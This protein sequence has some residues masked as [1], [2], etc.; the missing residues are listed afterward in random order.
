M[1]DSHD[2]AVAE[3]Q[4]AITS[5]TTLAEKYPQKLE[6][7]QN[8]A[9]VNN[10]LG[11]TLRLS[12]DKPDDAK[13]AY[14]TALTLQQ[15]LHGQSPD[16]ATYQRELARTHYNRGILYGKTAEPG[17][18]AFT[19]A[20]SDFRE[21]MRLLE[22]LVGKSTDLRTSQDLARACN[23]LAALLER[24]DARVPDAR[25]LYER[26]ID[27]IGDLVAKRP[28]NRQYRFELAKF[29]N[30]LSYLLDKSGHP[31]LAEQANRRALA[32]IAELARPAQSLDM[33]RA[34][35]HNLRGHILQALKPREAIAEYRASLNVW[36]ALAQAGGDRQADFHQRF[37]DLLLNLAAFSKGPPRRADAEALTG[38]A[39]VAYIA[40][41]ERA[42]TAGST[43]SARNVVDTLTD[44]MPELSD[45]VRRQM[46]GPLES[47]QKKLK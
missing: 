46:T 40:V 39:V 30:N 22:P 47:L 4:R 27:L 26:A 29:S 41:G 35:T 38:E 10:S 8:L 19:Q 33:E 37:G 17:Q 45:P 18:A 21:A 42:V 44:V 34:D 11:E 20:E 28:D 16:N 36:V 1:L 14:A 3:Y 24:D 15:A 23:N 32:L 9:S 7:R 2:A 5:F 13:N 25:V 31:D 12:G 6:Y 43:Q